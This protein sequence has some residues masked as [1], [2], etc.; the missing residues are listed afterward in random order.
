MTIAP[1]TRLG[2]YEADSRIGAEGIGKCGARATR[3]DRRVAI[4][5]L[6]VGSLPTRTARPAT[7]SR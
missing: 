6:S 5:L 7:L 2:P 4:K 3:A 1:G